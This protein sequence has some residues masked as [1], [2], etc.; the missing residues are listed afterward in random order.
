MSDE[1]EDGDGDEDVCR[2]HDDSDA[3][4]NSPGKKT[5]GQR[6]KHKAGAAIMPKSE[7]GDGRQSGKRNPGGP[8]AKMK[9]GAATMPIH[10]GLGE[11]DNPIYTKRLRSLEAKSRLGSQ[12]RL[13][14]NRPRGSRQYDSSSVLRLAHS[15]RLLVSSDD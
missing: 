12:D 14:P 6:T 1:D 5:E 7:K 11:P 15:D 9:A 13:P 4:A 10:E 2:L 8:E 3:S